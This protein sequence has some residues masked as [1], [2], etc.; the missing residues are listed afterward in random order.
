MAR[1]ERRLTPRFA[2]GAGL[3]A[4]VGG[5]LTA[6]CPL[7]AF[8]T[9]P[10]GDYAF[11]P[12]L[13]ANVAVSGLALVETPRVPFVLL[14]LSVSYARAQTAVAG[15][16]D[17]RYTALDGRLAL[18]VGKTLG[19]LTLYAAGRVFGGPVSWQFDG[20]AV[21]NGTDKFHRQVGLGLALRLPRAFDVVVE[22]LALGEESVIAAIG[23]GF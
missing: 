9:V 13:Q 4:L 7:N 6:S 21:M 19:R 14:A 5:G 8:C 22:G 18:A 1:L 12:G 11:T 16:A 20:A 23:W 15:V 10:G 17:A 2:V 3:G